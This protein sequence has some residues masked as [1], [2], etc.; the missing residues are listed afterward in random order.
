MQVKT[1][2]NRVEKYKSFVYGRVRLVQEAGEL[3]M[4]VDIA[5][6]A[7]GKPLCSECK[8]PASGYD[9]PGPARR[10]EFVPLWGIAVFFLYTM[11]RVDCPTCGVRVEAV[12]WATGKEQ[13]TTTYAWFLA[14]WARRLTWNDTALAFGTSFGKVYR[15][16][17]TAVAWGLEHRDL[18]GITAIGIDE[19]L[20]HR[21]HKYITVVYQIDQGC[22]RL[23]WVGQKRTI[24]TTLKFFRWFG[25][26]HTAALRFICSDMWRPYLKVIAYKAGHAMNVLDRFHIVAKMNKALDEVRAKEAKRLLADGYVPILKNSRWG[27]LKRPENL[28]PKQDLKLRELLRYNLATVRAYLLKKDFDRF[29]QY[30]S[31][32]WAG[33]FLDQWC[34]KT[35]R[36]RI[37]PMKKIARSLR[38]H[39]ALILN[40]FEAR[41]RHVSLGAVEGLN[42]KEKV[43]M[44][45]SYG[46]KTF[47][48]AE[49]ALY[50][51]LGKLPEPPSAHRFC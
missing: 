18:S 11:R 47:E 51:T 45:K 39:R 12:P 7:N 25:K 36:S 38:K 35:M 50:H 41:D 24:K 19:V 28:T 23:L 32:R 20:F 37:E 46:F 27:F 26:Q 43:V 17:Q 15:A 48:A 29:W 40:W 1:I 9:Q 3:R 44:R 6:R 8:R 2:L 31:T 22:K 16:V 33:W 34:R 4:L 5:A 14:R 13:L 10:F 42:N 30:R 21:G 49:V